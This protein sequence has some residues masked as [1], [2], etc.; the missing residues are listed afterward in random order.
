MD[1]ENAHVPTGTLTEISVPT[2]A[3]PRAGTVMSLALYR[4]CP[5]AKALPFVGARAL[6]LKSWTW[7]CCCCCCCC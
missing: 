2:S 5:A 3:R 7:S 4:S 6:G 1:G